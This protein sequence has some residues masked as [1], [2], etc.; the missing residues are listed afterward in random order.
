MRINSHELFGQIIPIDYS[1]V[2]YI[3][4]YFKN[5]F[6]ATSK[7]IAVLYS[8]YMP[9]DFVFKKQ[10]QVLLTVFRTSREKPFPTLTFSLSFTL[11]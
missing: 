2:H 7:V 4:N 10:Y 3:T 5:Q 1:T 6:I 11:A 8:T 9:T